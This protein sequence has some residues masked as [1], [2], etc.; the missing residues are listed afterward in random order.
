MTVHMFRVFIGRGSMA[1]SDVEARIQDWITSNPEWTADTVDHSLV[2]RNTAIDESGETYHAV[3]VRFRED[4][5][6]SNILQKLGDKL[7]D[8]VDWYRIG[9]H[10]CSHDEDRPTPCTWDGVEEWIAKDATIPADIPSF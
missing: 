2:E 7:K 5:T 1:V 4:D 9:Y 10:Q 8:K 6:K 3:V